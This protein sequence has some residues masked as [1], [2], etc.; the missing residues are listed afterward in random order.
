MHNDPFGIQRQL[1]APEEPVWT[2]I[3]YQSVHGRAGEIT[4]AIPILLTNKLTD[5]PNE[6]TRTNAFGFDTG[7]R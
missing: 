4:K 1:W 2:G 6:C 7:H 3:N 5:P